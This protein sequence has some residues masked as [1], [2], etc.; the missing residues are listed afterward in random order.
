M[1]YVVFVIVL[2]VIWRV[3]S[4]VVEDDELMMFVEIVMFGMLGEFLCD[5]CEEIVFYK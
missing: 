3:V 2:K 4:V 5:W 1:M